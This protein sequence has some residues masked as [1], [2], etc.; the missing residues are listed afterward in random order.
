MA[1]K[2]IN[3]KSGIMQGATVPGEHRDGKG[4]SKKGPSKGAA[5]MSKSDRKTSDR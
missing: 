5:G 3:A 4:M 1:G 2:S